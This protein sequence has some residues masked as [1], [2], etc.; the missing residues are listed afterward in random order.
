V[1]GIDQYDFA[2]PQPDI[3]Q[4]SRGGHVIGDVLRQQIASDPLYVLVRNNVLPGV[5]VSG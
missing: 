2:A 1:P 5:D 3:F 4:V